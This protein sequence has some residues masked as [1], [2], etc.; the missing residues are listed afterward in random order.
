MERAVTFKQEEISGHHDG[1]T[2]WPSVAMGLW[3]WLS[4]EIFGYFYTLFTTNTIQRHHKIKENIPR[5]NICNL[6]FFIWS[7]TPTTFRN[8]HV[9]YSKQNGRLLVGTIVHKGECFL[10][11]PLSSTTNGLGGITCLYDFPVPVRNQEIVTS[12]ELLFPKETFITI[13]MTDILEKSVLV[14]KNIQPNLRKELSGMKF[15]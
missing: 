10:F 6:Y 2:D 12:P 9:P 14:K 8:T 15:S 5:R 13:N 1:L 7:F 11:L 3:L 4:S